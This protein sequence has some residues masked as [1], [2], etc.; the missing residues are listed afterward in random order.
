M[1]GDLRPRWWL[2]PLTWVWAAV[3]GMWPIG[4]LIGLVAVV[5]IV[6][7]NRSRLRELRPVL[8][9]LLAVPVLSLVVAAL[10]PVGPR[11]YGA[12]LMVGG[13]A[14]FHAEWA[15][16]DFH[17]RQPALAALL[18]VLTIVVWL[19][20]RGAR[21]DWVSI[22]LLLM[23]AGW[24]AFAV[25]TVPVAAM[26]TVP[27]VAAA[28][29]TLVG[30]SRSAVRRERTLVAA[31]TVAAMALLALLA[32]VM[33]DRPASVPGWVNPALD[34][35]PAGTTVQT[36]DVM[37]GYLMWRHPDL[38]PVIDGYSDAY[39]T[40]HLQEQLDLQRLD[41][42]WQTTLRETRVRYALLPTSSRLALCT[43]HVRGLAGVA[44][45]S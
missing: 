22:L 16:T 38:N 36:T 5:G 4:V 32:P 34:R 28:I 43:E 40:R 6:L 26:M 11:L 31:M 37:G 18:I 7:D 44:P 24:G 12:V 42:G 20:R 19:V 1:A 13:R 25:R 14:K 35:L 21:P 9:R 17:Q 15:A 23:A 41:P 30:R 45:I 10:T 3:H 29:Q 39:T 8:L 33:A 2:V 27:F